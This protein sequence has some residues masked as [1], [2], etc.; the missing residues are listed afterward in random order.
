MATARPI[1]LEDEA[2]WVTAAQVLHLEPIHV[3]ARELVHALVGGALPDELV[4]AVAE[5]SGGN[6]LFIE[7]LLRMWASAGVLAHD[8]GH[9]VLT[10]AT[11]EVPFPPTVQAIYAGQLDDLPG[12]ARTAV[13]RAAVAGR[14][15][16]VAA[17]PVLEVDA[18]ESALDVLGRRGLVTGPTSDPSLG[19]SYAYRHALLRDAGYTS[20]ARAERAKF[21]CGWPTGSR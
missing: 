20:L 1:L 15:F 13:R 8:T 19:P 21:I 16:A 11:D 4:K 7:E 2:E 12:G 10:A 5:R 3:G 6:A 9:W 17:L 14:R 18:H